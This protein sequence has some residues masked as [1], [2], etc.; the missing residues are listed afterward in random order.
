MTR[1]FETIEDYQRHLKNG[2]GQGEGINYKPWFTVRDVK[3]PKAFRKIIHGLKTNR[4]HHMLSAIEAELFYLLDFKD[5]VID[6]REQ[7]PLLPLELSQKIATT[8]GVK[9][10]TVPKTQA[11]HI[12]TTDLLI[13]RIDDGKPKYFAYCV[14]PA[15]ELED[16]RIKEKIEIERIWWELLEVPFEIYTGTEATDIQSRNIAWIT[17]ILRSEMYFDLQPFVKLALS[18]IQ[19]GNYLKNDLCVTFQERFDIQSV[20]A[21]NL[22]RLLIAKKHIVVDTKTA[23]LETSKTIKIDRVYAIGEQAIGY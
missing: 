23:L 20:D 1:K 19:Q 8:I 5:D 12:M 14:K 3:G 21:L 16:E 18:N 4:E 6:I 11:P 10:P 2:Y 13:T 9:H 22:L 15:E 7:F 17:D